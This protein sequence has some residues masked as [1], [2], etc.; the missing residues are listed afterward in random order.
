M[1]SNVFDISKIEIAPTP[2]CEPIFNIKYHANSVV[3]PILAP[4]AE[5]CCVYDVTIVASVQCTW[6]VEPRTKDDVY[7]SFE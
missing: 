3:E 6:V 1:Q 5:C 2:T 7:N 4:G